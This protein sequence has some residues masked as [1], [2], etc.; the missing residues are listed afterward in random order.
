MKIIYVEGLGGFFHRAL[1]RGLIKKLKKVFPHVEIEKRSY[2]DRRPI[3][4]M[5]VVLIGHSWGAHRILNNAQTVGLLLTLDPRVG[6]QGKSY[7]YNTQGVIKFDAVN[8][9]QTGFMRGYPV[10][11]AKNIILKCS[12]LFMP[13]QK[14]VFERALKSMKELEKIV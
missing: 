1:Y 2:L 12:H 14:K 8:F 10:D 11:V 7:V 13:F 5:K 4:D 9:Y 6:F 3:D